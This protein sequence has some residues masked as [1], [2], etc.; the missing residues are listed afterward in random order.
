MSEMPSREPCRPVALS[1]LWSCLLTALL[2]AAATRAQIARNLTE[3]IPG[4]PLAEALAEYARQTGVQVVY[5]S[6][7]VRGKSSKGAPAGLRPR[8]ALA[9]LL[10]GT[11]L[12][13]EL[14]NERSVHIFGMEPPLQRAPI[15]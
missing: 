12:Q 7:I 1:V 10:D 9:R 5:V 11:G 13:F 6:E 8:A 3:D 14:L 2:G 4:Q 15:R